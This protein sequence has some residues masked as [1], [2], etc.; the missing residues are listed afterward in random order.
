M[1]VKELIE[2][3][4]EMDQELYVFTKGYEGGYDHLELINP[5][6]RDVA[7]EVHDEWYY[8]KHDDADQFPNVKGD[9]VVKGIIL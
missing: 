8:G 7:L 1:R 5:A 6:T 2:K 3:L 4:Q 9:R